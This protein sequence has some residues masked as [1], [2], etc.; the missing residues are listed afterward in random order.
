MVSVLKPQG[1]GIP[2]RRESNDVEKF[3]ALNIE[4]KKLEDRIMEARRGVSLAKQLRQQA[5]WG[6][7]RAGQ[8][9]KE[10]SRFSSWL[11]TH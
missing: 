8:G 6:L 3:N 5:R 4:I 9:S 1:H 7:A 2:C 11:H 10:R